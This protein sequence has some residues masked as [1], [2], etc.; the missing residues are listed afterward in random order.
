MGLPA[1]IIPKS[2]LPGDHQVMNARS[3]ERAGGAEILYEQI[4]PLNGTL[5][6]WIDGKV[7]AQKLLSLI[8][9]DTRLKV[10]ART[11]RLLPKPGRPRS[12]RAHHSR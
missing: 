3:M 8:G 6:E 9:D 10:N 4:D 2:N 5:S 11:Q 7:L 1:L 12:Y